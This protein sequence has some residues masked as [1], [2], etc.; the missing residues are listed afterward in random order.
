MN[1]LS[2]KNK[3]TMTEILNSKLNDHNGD[4]KKIMLKK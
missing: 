1:T 3:N 4:L 2:G